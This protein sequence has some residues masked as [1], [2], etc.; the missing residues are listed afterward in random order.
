MN[1]INLYRIANLFYRI[2]VPLL[3]KIIYFVQFLLFNSIVPYTAKI[4]KGTYCSYGGVG[5]VIHKRAVI[6]D[7]CVLGQGIT[8][9]GRSRIPEVPVIGN[10][11]YIAS[12]ARVLGNV[13]IGDNAII[14]ANSVV[15]NDVPEGCVAAGVPARII[16]TGK[17]LEDYL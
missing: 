15:I 17:K 10:R 6:G 2:R 13:R 3:P 12:G 5:V 14:G 11:V 4:G 7:D 1:V 16:K 9:G 8:I